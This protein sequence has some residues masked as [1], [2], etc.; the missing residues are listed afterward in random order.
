MIWTGLSCPASLSSFPFPAELAPTWT[1]VHPCSFLCSVTDF[2]DLQS[3][4]LK[5][6]LHIIGKNRLAEKLFY[7]KPKFMIKHIK[8]LSTLQ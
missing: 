3:V 1:P 2:L 6:T 8:D 5:K 4:F 7:V